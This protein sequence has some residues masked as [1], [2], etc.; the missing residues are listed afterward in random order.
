MIGGSGDLN[1]S[2]RNKNL[3]RFF[4]RFAQVVLVAHIL[5][6]TFVGEAQCGFGDQGGEASVDCRLQDWAPG[7]HGHLDIIGFRTRHVAGASVGDRE[8]EH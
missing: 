7:L 6:I 8:D 1:S 2:V 3:S 4:K 5:F